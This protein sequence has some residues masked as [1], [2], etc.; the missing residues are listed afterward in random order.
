MGSEYDYREI[1]NKMEAL[2]SVFI[3]RGIPAIF[4]EMGILSKY[5]NNI[6]S[7]REYLYTLSS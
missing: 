7:Y 5:N 4:G 2:K 3:D 1:M 6:S